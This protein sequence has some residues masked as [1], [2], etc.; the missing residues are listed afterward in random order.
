MDREKKNV[1]IL[2]TDDCKELYS[3]VVSGKKQR[4]IEGHETAKN[5]SEYEY[6][7]DA[8]A[9]SSHFLHFL[10]FT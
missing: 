6:E 7:T 8:D 2:T 5:K 1:S 3:S 10:V 4:E 9:S